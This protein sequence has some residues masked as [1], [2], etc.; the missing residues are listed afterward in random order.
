MSWD[1][2]HSDNILNLQELRAEH[3]YRL[4]DR[5]ILVRSPAEIP[6]R[7]CIQTGSGAHPASCT[8]G[9]EG[10]FPGVKALPGRDSGHPP[11]S[12]AAV[13]NE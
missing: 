3:G 12:S 5:A 8:M 11:S 6:S 4:E 1:P 10:P 7:L 2:Y 13:E 9:T